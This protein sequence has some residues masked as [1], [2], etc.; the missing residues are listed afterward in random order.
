MRS[1]FFLLTF[2]L[3]TPCVCAEPLQVL[4]LSGGG[5]GPNTAHNGKINHLK[6]IPEF[7]RS[8]IEM[9]YTDDLEDMNSRTL[10]KY[11]AVI[12]Y[13]GVANGKKEWVDALVAYVENGGGLVALHHTCGAFENSPKFISLIGGQFARHGSGWFKATHVKRW[14]NHPAL[15]GVP[16]F[17]TWDETYV[18][19]NLNDDRTDLQTRDEKGRAEPWTWVRTQGKGRVFYSAYGHDGRVWENFHFQKMIAAATVW[20]ANRDQKTV[21]RDIPTLTYREDTNSN[22]HNHEK[23]QDPQRIQ[24]QLSPQDSAKCLVLPRGFEAQLVAHEP[25]IKNP[26]DVVWDD[27]GRMYVAETNDYPSIKDEGS[28]RI[29]ICD[30]TDGDG[31]ADR[32]TVFAEGFSLHTGMCWVN[33]GIILAQAPDMFFLKDTD[34][35]D[36]AD[37]V[38]KINSGWGT[39]DKHGGPSNL[40]YGLDNRIYGCVGGGGHWDK[41]GRFSAGIWRMDVDGSNFTP[42]GNLGD[43]SWGLGISEDFEL[44][45]SSANR[46]PAKHV[47]APYPYFEAIGMKKRGALNIFDSHTYFPLTVTR[48]GDHFGSY[49]AASGFDVYTARTFPEKY[50]NKA[51][52]V[53]GP[54]GK[55]LGQFFLR[56]DGKGSYVASNEGSLAASF[57]E[58]TAPIGGRI[59]P[60]GHVYL[61][62]WN[63]LI[64]LHGGEIQNALRDKTHGRIYRIVHK[65]G[66]PSAVLDL[67]KADTAELVA[68]L[69][70]DNMFWRVMAQQK[71]VQQKRMDAVPLLIEFAADK[72]LDA[73]DSNPAVIHALWS[74]H[75]LGQLKGNNAQALA[76]AHAA[77]NHRSAAVRKN[78]VRVLPVSDQSTK[79][80]AA[81]LDERNANALRYILLTISTMPMSDALGETLYAMSNRFNGKPAL[82]APFNLAL[83]RH[84]G[85]QLVERLI[86]RCPKR[87]HTA[88]AAVEEES[89]KLV[90]MLKNPSFEELNDKGMPAHWISK[91]HN[92]VAALS[93]D[94]TVART[95][96]HSGRIESSKGGGG[97]FLVIP[98]LEP[99]E[100]MLSAWART[101]DV[102][103][104]HGVL[105]RAAG[106]GVKEQRSSA[107]KGTHGDWQ[108]LQMNFRVSQEGGV[109]LFC[110]FGA[111]A[112]TTGAVWFDDVSLFQLSSEK[113][114]VIE[115]DKVETLLARQAFAK[116][117]DAVIGLTGLVNTKSESSTTIFMEGLEDAR[118]VS[119]TES[120]VKRLKALA[121]N[122]APKHKKSLALFAANNGIDIG[123]S[124]LANSIK[125][126]EAKI[127]KG[128][129]TKGKV[130]TT[131]CIVC[132]SPDFT[133]VLEHRS[134]SLPQLSTWY[135]QS[136]LQKFK[137]NVRGNDATDSDGFMMKALM[138]SY[139]H[140]QIADMVAYI[141]T[142]KPKAHPITLGGDPVRGKALYVSCIDCHQANGRGKP[143][144]KS[145][146]IVGHS[147]VYIVNQLLKFKDGSRGSGK[148][149][150]QGRIMQ[151]SMQTLK[152]EQAMKDVAAYLT[153][154]SVEVDTVSERRD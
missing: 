10:A 27:R 148:G 72:G 109:L 101:Q 59:G 30:D 37:V 77:L 150:L 5:A 4:F 18:H 61:L 103:G 130:P 121:D 44:F 65:A 73:I 89:V 141:K 154:L 138:R 34:G 86:A 15:G 136:Q 36:K 112:P 75:G 116:G 14:M 17:M 149:D 2:V 71:I 63:N 125:G 46:G 64:M 70:N 6:L 90:N 47:H 8:G 127:V 29:I 62:D 68:T 76:V 102:V 80:L 144:L 43:N 60:D 55:L 151:M 69:K 128:D 133:G 106:N 24:N 28:D 7:L 87:E 11:N 41:R 32:F 45:A 16:D 131:A 132:H 97:E 94:S 85:T 66:K 145:P 91:V 78:A 122:A 99:G 124:E 120:Q 147:D 92:G 142:H 104:P 21:A 153:T 152:D 107:L 3:L 48:T 74:L 19:K 26:I 126:F 39:G 118:S 42:I 139:S 33:G 134:P 105:L 54:T 13:R 82:A 20:A 12:I 111:W 58:Y 113:V 79:L 67:S 81:M 146:S 22:L 31:K 23:R 51:A 88:E 96:E 93:V 114:A 100:Y 129:A 115:S 135:L 140:Q 137:H 9:I 98:R 95:G 123:L 53:G 119:F 56:P 1:F 117:A 83:I 38:K 143:E 57:D 84:G 108:K 49:T 110:L 25:D 40:R 52:F 35:D 50:W